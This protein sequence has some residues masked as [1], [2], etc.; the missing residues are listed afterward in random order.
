MEGL[1]LLGG[2]RR[3]GGGA[4]VGVRSPYI[5]TVR[6]VRV[7]QRSFLVLMTQLPVIVIVGVV[8]AGVLCRLVELSTLQHNPMLVA[9][10][11]ISLAKRLTQVGTR[12]EISRAAR[13]VAFLVGVKPRCSNDHARA[14]Q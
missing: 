13:R 3:R 8:V 2:F 7:R 9:G 14:S 4:Q 12:V 5:A 11:A 1:C 10:R 6:L